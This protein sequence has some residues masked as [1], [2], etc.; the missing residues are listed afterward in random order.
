MSKE[1]IAMIT[2][3]AG[4]IG[5]ATA[6]LLHQ[7]GYALWLVDIQEKVLEEMK[8]SYPDA[9]ISVC[10]LNNDAEVATLCKEILENDDLFLAFINAGVVTPG[11]VIDLPLEKIDLQLQVNLRSAIHLNHTCGQKLKKQGEGH[12]I[13]TVSMGGILGLKGSA[14]YSATKFGLRGFLMS[15]HSEMKPYGVYVSGI[16]PSGVD[17]A[18]LRMEA[19][20]PSGSALNFLSEPQKVETVAHKVIKAIKGKKVEYYVPFFDSLTT[21][22][23]GS[24]PSLSYRFLPIFEKIGE[25]GRKKFIKKRN[26]V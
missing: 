14:T 17:T 24:F 3:A 13:N 2:G 20:H 16:Y 5:R 4:A 1:K 26:L 10:N 19:L 11:D 22:F 18:M 21:K 12:I 6:K 7:N 9:R 25:K 15:F 8:E 23:F